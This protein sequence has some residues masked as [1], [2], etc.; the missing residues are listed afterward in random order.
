MEENP[1]QA[2]S[3][4]EPTTGWS[5]TVIVFISLTIGAVYF[6]VVVP[7]VLSGRLERAWAVAPALLTVVS[8]LVYFFDPNGRAQRC[9]ERQLK[10][11]EPV[12]DTELLESYFSAEVVDPEIP[13]RVRTILA[14]HMCYPAEKMLPDDD[15]T[16][17]W[18]DLD[19]IDLMLELEQ[20]FGIKIDDTDAEH[21]SCTIH[22]IS[23]L[24]HR[25]RSTASV[26]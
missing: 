10:E 1:Y 18:D 25:L 5:R 6:I 7:P 26:P 2:P 20:Q 23:R 11:R 13:G 17:F 9:Y 12:D 16:F 14:K 22:D 15:L 4:S 3:S 8:V 24:I 21:T 19:G